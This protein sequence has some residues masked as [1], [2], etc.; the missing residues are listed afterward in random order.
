MWNVTKPTT[1]SR[2]YPIGTVTIVRSMHWTPPSAE[3]LEV[4]WHPSRI[5]STPDTLGGKPRIANRRISVQDVV[6]WHHHM[7]LSVEEI[8]TKYNLSLDDV[9]AALTYYADHRDEIDEAIRAGEA[10][11]SEMRQRHPSKLKAGRDG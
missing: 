4:K 2:L 1:E 8:A 10:F 6:I 5:V 3:M 9:Q 7:G 11:V